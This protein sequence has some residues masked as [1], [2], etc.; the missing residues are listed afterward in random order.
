MARRDRLDE[1]IAALAADS[2]F[3]DVTRRLGCLRGISTLTGFAL[4]VEI[5]DWSR[6]TGNSIGAYLGLVPSEHSTGSSRRLGA[7]TKTGNSHVRRLLIESAWHHRP[8]Y[9]VGPT[10]RAR[11]ELAPEP[12]WVRA[13]AGNLRLHRRWVSYNERHKKFTIATTAVA[14][15]LAGWCWSLAVLE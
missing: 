1:A 8:H 6:F 14:R 9:S 11:W 10:L 2:E 7:I 12:V 13:H 3:T 15:E 5:G 4:A